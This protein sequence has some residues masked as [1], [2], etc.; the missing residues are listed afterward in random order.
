MVE[1]QQQA[2]KS[3]SATPYS[4][5]Y[6]SGHNRASQQQPRNKHPRTQDLKDTNQYGRVLPFTAMSPG[7]GRVGFH[8]RTLTLGRLISHM[9]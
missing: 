1:L 8:K 2:D 9:P 4:R 6:S 5:L 7:P 3:S